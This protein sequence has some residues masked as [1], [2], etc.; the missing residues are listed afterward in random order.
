MTA[1]APSD[2]G[3]DAATCITDASAAVTPADAAITDATAVAADDAPDADIAAGAT[4]TADDAGVI[5]D[6]HR[7]DEPM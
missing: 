7:D 5:D 3:W 2:T 1:T 6:G 4:T